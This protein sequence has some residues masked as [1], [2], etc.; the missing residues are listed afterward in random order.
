M[1]RKRNTHTTAPIGT[2]LG[3]GG[4]PPAEYQT[5]ALAAAFAEYD[6]LVAFKAEA[7]N[8]LADLEANLSGLRL[9][10]H[11]DDVQH[12][13]QAV[14]A[15]GD[16]TATPAAD[17]LDARYAKAQSNARAYQESLEQCGIEIAAGL[18]FTEWEKLAPSLSKQEKKARDLVA[19]KLAEAEAAVTDLARIIGAR[20]WYADAMQFDPTAQFTLAEITGRHTE[21]DMSTDKTISARA[22]FDTIRNI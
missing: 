14:N 13:V 9:Q 1:A 4:R 10:A 5:D 11:R 18:R 12:R 21:A 7:D 22:M 17:A 6:Q 16:T 8:D 2:V 20:E 19:K 15:G 3:T